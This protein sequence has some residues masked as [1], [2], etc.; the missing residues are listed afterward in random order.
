M[1]EIANAIVL[2][3]CEDYRN[4]IRGNIPGNVHGKLNRPE[5]MLKDVMKF[6]RS[7][8]YGQL[9]TVDYQYLIDK[10]NAEWEEGKLLIK[11]GMDVD[12]P[13]SKK[14]YEYECPLC[15]GKAETYIIR[16]VSP[17]RK[18]GSRTITYIKLFECKCHGLEQIKYKQ[19][20]I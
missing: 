6:F 8:W 5:E 3:A 12:C 11:A 14:H 1:I 9:T 7:Q 15:G 10:M 4:A 19:E 18:D 2:Q 20:V 16:H 17:K 13:K